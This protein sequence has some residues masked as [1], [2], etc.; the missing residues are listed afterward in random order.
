MSIV[1]V[2]VDKSSSNIDVSSLNWIKVG[3]DVSLVFY[4]LVLTR[5]TTCS[6]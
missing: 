3:V 4:D 6:N 1:G 5:E 2:V